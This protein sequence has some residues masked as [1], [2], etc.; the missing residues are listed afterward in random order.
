MG[1]RIVNYMMFYTAAVA[2]LSGCGSSDEGVKNKPKVGVP[3]EGSFSLLTGGQENLA[4][5]SALVPSVVYFV[6][7]T[8]TTCAAEADA[9]VSYLKEK[10]LVPAPTNVKITSIVVGATK[11]DAQDWSEAHSVSWT[12]GYQTP[13]QNA[14]LLRQY[15]PLIQTPCVVVSTPQKGVVFAKIG[16]V[17]IEEIIS[18]TGEWK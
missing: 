16:A 1:S 14:S 7:D 9:L 10:S 11:E 12:V 3:L 18:E 15:C 8:C 6:S 4:T 17:K 5:S 13:D 2:I